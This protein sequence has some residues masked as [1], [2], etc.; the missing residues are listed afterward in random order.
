ML[1]KVW[2]AVSIVLI[3]VI[4]LLAI[5]LAG[6]RLVGLKPYAVLSGSMS[7]AYPVGALI[8]VETVQ[9][10]E[11]KAGDAI[12]FYMSDG[13]TVATHRVVKIDTQSQCFYTKGDANENADASPVYFAQ[14]IGSPVFAMPVLGYI[15]VFI[16]TPFGLCI[17]G[18]V[19]L[20][21][22]LL[23]FLPGIAKMEAK[24]ED[25]KPLTSAETAKERLHRM[26]G[27]AS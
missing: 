5:L 24:E 20:A 14:L 11:V 23:S 1:K 22:I 2:N 4:A 15:S 17:T 18:I 6:V 3:S 12:T 7:P 19:V 27:A 10:Q 21:V 25:D 26:K 13:S 8:Y 16:A 9:P